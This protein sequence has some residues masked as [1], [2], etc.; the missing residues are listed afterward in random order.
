MIEV[1]NNYIGQSGK[2]YKS[3]Y[4]AMLGWVAKKVL[5]EKLVQQQSPASSS[6]SSEFNT[7][8]L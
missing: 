7:R 4:H 1:L 8:D 2:T 3:H 6:P 5:D